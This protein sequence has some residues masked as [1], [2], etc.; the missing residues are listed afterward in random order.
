MQMTTTSQ[1]A[2]NNVPLR[3]VLI[4]STNSDLFFEKRLHHMS[5]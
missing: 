2:S 4:T 5:N 3:F 1:L